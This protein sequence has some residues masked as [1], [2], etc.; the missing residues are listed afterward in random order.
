M[1]GDKTIGAKTRLAV[2][3]GQPVA[4][5][6][7][8]AMMNAAFA[9][10]NVDAAYLA[11]DLDEQAMQAAVATLLATNALGANVTVPHKAVAR[12][13]ADLCS[14]TVT[15]LDAANCLVFEDGGVR[16]ENTDA[17]GLLHALRSDLKKV[18]G[19]ALI[20]GAGGAARAALHALAEL[21]IAD[22]VVCNRDDKR[23]RALLSTARKLVPDVS[24]EGW[25]NI[26]QCMAESALIINAT[27][28]QVK[29]ETLDLPLNRVS[30]HAAIYDL[31]YGDTPLVSAAKKRG[32]K[33]FDGSGMLLHQ[34]AVAFTLWT[35]KPAPLAA[36]RSA[37][38]Y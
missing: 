12:K 1:K 6:K 23:R 18:K 36:M 25:Q 28:A 3:L 4:H 21:G 10:R 34:A 31:T 38:L 32:L 16:A 7:S 13:L 29:S 11:W 15:L 9:A 33:A 27:S 30:K 5:S 17:P 8:P 26:E 37:L 35:K 20:L 19:P 22:V 2:L 14:E 24:L